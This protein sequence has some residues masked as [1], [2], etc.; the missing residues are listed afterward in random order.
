MQYLEK[1]F[2]RNEYKSKAQMTFHNMSCEFVCNDTEFGAEQILKIIGFVNEV[3]RRYK[4][5]NV[6]IYFTFGNVRILDKLSY[7]TFECIC[8][9]LIKEHH[10]AISLAWNPEDEIWTQGV[11]SS[12]L[13]II[14]TLMACKDSQKKF[15]EK[16][17]FEIY[18]SHFRRVINPPKELDENYVGRLQQEVNTF[19]TSFSIAEKY[20]NDV[21]DMIGE[22]VGNVAEHAQTDCL[23]DIDVTTDHWRIDEPKDSEPM[24]YGVNIVILNFSDV[25]FGDK[26]GDRIRKN[27][28][29]EDSRYISLKDAYD[30]HSEFFSD[31]YLF[32]DFCNLS[33]LQ[34]KI[35][36]SPEKGLAG[37]KGLTSLIESLQHK[38]EDSTC[39]LLSGKRVVAFDK[40]LLKYDDGEWLGF[41]HSHNFFSELPDKGV[42]GEC[43]VDFPGTAYNLN[44]V[45][46]REANPN[47]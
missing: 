41:N 16:F 17:I 5:I 37:G 31:N 45:L 34:H 36:G 6:P 42:I 24:Y 35:S 27:D 8:Y 38:S 2:G 21:V 20:R 23:L 13:K 40:E 10:H 22:I 3:H 47:E 9:W 32:E 18:K 28:L 25:L 4:H 12:P 43:L 29:F 39:Y 44:F 7:I 30:F 14:N 15:T 11:F 1:L 33:S 26:L 19:L 46:K